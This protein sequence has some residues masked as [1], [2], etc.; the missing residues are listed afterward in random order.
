VKRLL[1]A[2]QFLTV[3]PVRGATAPPGECVAWFPWVGAL[4]GVLGAVLVGVHPLF[5]VGAWILLTGAFHEDGLADCA[6]AF[7]AHRSRDR[8]LAILKDSRI[9][10]FGA[11]ALVF[12]IALRWQALERLTIEPWRACLASHALSRASMAV[13]AYTTP[14]AG[15]GLGKAFAQQL[16]GA[17]VLLAA[18][19]AIAVGIH[20][21][22]V[23]ILVTVIIT[24]LARHF[25]LVRIGG[26][27][28]DC[29]GALCQTVETAVLW[30]AGR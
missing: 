3:L 2:L 17:S 23:T 21:G 25:F 1:G 30:V 12:S 11:V 28:G 8:I 14:P 7:R 10:A 29:L 4:V 27:T 15:E 13:L 6:D 16:T 9:G 20:S 18:L 5:A 26:V 19:P 22:P 24:W